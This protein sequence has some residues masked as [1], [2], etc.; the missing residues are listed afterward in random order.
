MTSFAPPLIYSIVAPSPLPRCW[1]AQSRSHRWAELRSRGHRSLR[2]EHSGEPTG[3]HVVATSSRSQLCSGRC[4]L[5]QCAIFAPRCVYSLLA[6]W[7]EVW[8]HGAVA[9]RCASRTCAMQCVCLMRY[10]SDPA[11]QLGPPRTARDFDR[12][13]RVAT[14][15]VVTEWGRATSSPGMKHEGRVNSRL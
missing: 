5:L 7:T 6:G 9:T 2:G 3:P 11:L 15:S 14:R 10:R 4:Q 1:Q 12:Q 13:M 8:L